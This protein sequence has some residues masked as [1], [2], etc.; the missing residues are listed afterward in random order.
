[1]GQ[2]ISLD[3]APG[4]TGELIV[5]VEVDPEFNGRTVTVMHCQNGVLQNYKAV[6]R[7]GRVTF[8]V[9]GSLSPFALFVRGGLLPQTGGY[10]LWFLPAALLCGAAVMLWRRR[11]EFPEE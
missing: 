3:P 7:E 9:Q 10:L 4:F 5:T 11:K 6:A 2:N 1:M 8:T